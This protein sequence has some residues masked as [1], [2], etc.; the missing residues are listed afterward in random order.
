[1]PP[2]LDRFYAQSLQWGDCANYVTDETSS[3]LYDGKDLK[4]AKLRVPLDYAKPDGREITVAVLRKQAARQSDRVGSL[5][6]NPGGPGQS[7][8]QA[9]A[10]IAA[11]AW[12]DPL[13]DRFDLVGFDPRGIG[14]SEPSVKCLSDAE[15]DADRLEPP[16]AGTGPE[17]VAAVEKE[18]KEYVDKCVANTGPDVLA[19]IGTRDVVKDM[20]VLRSALGEAKLNY[21]GFSYGTRIGSAYAEAFPGNVRAMVLDGAI[22]PNADRVAHAIGQATGFKKAFDAFAAS[23]VTKPD[24]PL[25]TDAAKAEAKLDAMLEPLKT[26]PLDVGSR[27]LSYSDAVTAIV[28]CLYGEELWET[29]EASLDELAN[30]KATVLVK[31][32]DHYLGRDT[33]GKYTNIHDVFTAVHCVDEPP[34]KDRAVLE[35]QARR[36]REGLPRSAFN[37]DEDF[38][39]ALDECAFWPVPNTTSPHE[40]K[41]AGLPKVLV[42]SSTGDPATPFES[43]VRLASALNATL[44]TVEANSHTAFLSDND[45]VNDIGAKYL[46]DL[47]QPAEGTKCS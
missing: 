25:G 31:L 32:A 3:E 17:A 39:A 20:D 5:L 13:S 1:M 4:C 47:R 26:K 42:V 33:S 29:L 37:E 19:N 34:V 45:C 28:Q 21:V 11:D 27:K 30:G 24:C 43:G 9:A 35:D 38:V 46:I 22:D 23:C 41:V 15:K 36:I 14:S 40:L 2:G 16:V 6:L 10:A 44:L 18:N 8:M 12:D 7:G